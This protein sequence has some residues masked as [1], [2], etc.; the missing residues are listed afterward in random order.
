MFKERYAHILQD[1]PVWQKI[2][3]TPSA[4]Y[5]W[6]EKSTYIQKPPYF[7]HFTLQTPQRS[8]LENMRTLALFGD[9]VTT[10]H[11]SPAGAFSKETP[12]GKY[13]LSKG[14]KESEFNSYG[15]RR[16]NHEV[17]MRGTF[18][19]VR[20]KN[21]LAQG[22]EGGVT[23]LLPDGKI[24]PIFDACEEYRRR[25]VSLI[26]FAGKDYG[27]GSSRDWAAKGTY[28][29]GVRAVVAQ[30]FERIH[31]SNLIG[32]GVL[33][34]QFKEN[35]S[36]QSWH[37]RGDETFTLEGVEGKLQPRQ[38]VFLVVSSQ[39]QKRKIPL[40]LRLDTTIEIEYYQH[41]GIMPYV[42]RQLLK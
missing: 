34:L 16:G 6:D 26:I 22:K 35:E 30:S 29:L 13:L 21:A 36:W 39:G 3:V 5:Q 4:Q 31:R 12:A 23:T 40:I 2:N 14:V 27:M 10:D 32:M 33:P 9:S 42:L 37:I 38:E 17:M 25:G 8:H 15:S 24:M 41:G 1:N 28:L 18:A 7:E 19:N 11:I 20:L